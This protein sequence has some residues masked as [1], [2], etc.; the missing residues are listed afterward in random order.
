MADILPGAEPGSWNGDN[1]G[2]LVLHGFI[3]NPQSMRP[4]AE[5]AAAAGFTVEMPLLP[6]H[7]TAVE[8]MLSTEWSDYRDTAAAAFDDL[9]ARTDKTFV[10]GLSMGGTLAIWLAAHRSNVDGL[11]A[12]N[13]AA[14]PQP[15]LAELLGPLVEAGETLVDGVGNDVAKEGVVE[16]AYKQMPL[17]PLLS[18]GLA[19]DELQE[20]LAAIDCPVLILNAPDDH[21]VPPASSDHLATAVSGPVTRISLDRSFHVATIDH[22]AEL[23]QTS[24]VAFISD[25]I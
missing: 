3:G 23:I 13:A 20:H 7:G 18:L 17:G 24:A 9:A 25:L 22:D 11:I 2:V 19:V 21:V 16:F 5:A 6:G 10:A 15:E 4:L 1:T 8:D 14:M 12:I